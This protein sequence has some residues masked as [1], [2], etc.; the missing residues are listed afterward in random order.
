MSANINKALESHALAQAGMST[1]TIRNALRGALEAEESDADDD[2]THGHLLDAITAIGERRGWRN[3][4]YD[5]AQGEID[6]LDER[7]RRKKAR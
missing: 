1:D 3:A 4:A 6:G 5:V 2:V 7:R